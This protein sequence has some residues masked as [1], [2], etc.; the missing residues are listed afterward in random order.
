MGRAEIALLSGDVVMKN[1][2]RLVGG[3]DYHLIQNH[4]LTVKTS[5]MRICAKEN[6]VNIRHDNGHY[7]LPRIVCASATAATATSK[8]IRVNFLFM[9]I[10]FL[11]FIGAMY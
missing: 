5:Y 1:Q 9:V 8:T 11:F 4:L 10:G 2:S 3:T 6:G 7:T